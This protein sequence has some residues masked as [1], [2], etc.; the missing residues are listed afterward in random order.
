MAPM[1]EPEVTR[2]DFQRYFPHAPTALCIRECAR[3]AKLRECELNSP[4]F[5]VG[6]G[7]GVFANLAFPGLEAWGIDINQAELRLA[8]TS[9]A[10][11]K[12]ILG[13]VTNEDLPQKYFATC[14]AN[15]SLEHVPRIDLA[16]RA[17]FESLKEGGNF[18]TFVPNAEWAE[19]LL[20]YRALS[21]VGAGAL[22][23]TLQK[24]IDEFFVHHHL[25]DAAGWKQLVEDAGFE[26]EV[27][28]PVLSSANT[29]AYE[30]FLLPSLLGWANK[31][32]TKRWTHLPTVRSRIAG[33]V[34][35]ILKAALT[36]GDPTPTAEFL[37]VGRRPISS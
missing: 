17:I 2:E 10:Y 3:L 36:S 35:S 4:L 13:D 23:K 9:G 25:Y 31:K 26:V 21:A 30:M 7:D 8:E 33:P 14:V 18:I 24:S 15:C 20:S 11:S 6:C 29:T 28:E 27:I 22:A 34:Y 32:L 1:T 37:I 19:H 12:L 16:L 5:D